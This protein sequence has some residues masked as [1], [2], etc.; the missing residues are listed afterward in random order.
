MNK[1]GYDGK[2]LGNNSQGIQ[3]FIQ[4]YVRLRNE[5]LGYEQNTSNDDINF[6]KEESSRTNE[7]TKS[8]SRS[9]EPDTTTTTSNQV[10]TYE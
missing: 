9:N 2:G 7:S 10:K 5:G 4:V 1:M 8:S 3:K 6:V